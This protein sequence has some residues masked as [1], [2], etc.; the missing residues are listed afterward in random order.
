LLRP[1][2]SPDFPG[3]KY[4][5]RLKTDLGL[6]ITRRSPISLAWIPGDNDQL[7]L[8][9]KT[10]AK[11]HFTRAEGTKGKIRLRLLTSQPTPKKTIKEGNQDKVV[12]DV[13]RTLR[14]EGDPMF[15]PDQA[16]VTAQILVPSDLP[17]PPS[18]L[19]LVCELT[20]G[21]RTRV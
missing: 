15:G 8:G 2:L 7:Y 21:A 17:R 4:Q 1:A 11:I 14:L 18:D 16:D 20:S 12:D 13:D 10:P 9:G 3:S 19:V 5:P 6:A